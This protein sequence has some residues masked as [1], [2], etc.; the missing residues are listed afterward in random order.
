MTSNSK[1]NTD[2]IAP[3]KAGKTGLINQ[4]GGRFALFFTYIH[5]SHDLA[6]GLLP[7]LLPFIREDL[8]LNYLQA[9][10]LVSAFSL[11]AGIS[12][13][14]GGWLSDRLSKTKAITL[15]LGGVGIS[16]I[17][18]SFAPSYYFLIGALIALGIFA[19]FYHP[20][21]I[22]ALTTHFEES[23]RGKVVALH[24]IGGSLGF[25][26][27]PLLGAIIASRFNWHLAYIL[28]GLPALVAAVLVFTQMKLAPIKSSKDTFP[29]RR[30]G[31]KSTGIW[32][33][34]KPAFGIIAISIAMQLITGPIMSFVSLFLIDVHQLTAAAGSMWVTAIRFGG[35]AGNLIGG[36]LTDK[37]GRRNTIFL[38]LIIFGPVVL[39]LARL[40]FGFA[41]GVIF[42]LFGWLMTMRETTMQTLLMD[43]SPPQLRATVIGIYFG[44]GQQGSS[45]IQPVAGDFMDAI[46]IAGVFNAIAFISVGLSVLTIMLLLRN[47]IK[48]KAFSSISKS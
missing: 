45:I 27:G 19:G 12:Q 3:G 38:I 37:W 48:T 33:V 24:M 34:F 47:T 23:R 10:F 11:T 40:P 43:N 18:I 16:A 41:L 21:S 42:I 15:G 2:I 1:A 6:T 32:Q 26:L 44:F 28:L 14:L 4:W 17:V 7:A 35:L 22:S 31:Q 46:G 39:L 29:S 30:A 20:S 8:G 9:G 13:L 36:W 25:G 5:L